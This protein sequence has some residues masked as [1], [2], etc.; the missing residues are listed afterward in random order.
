M[1]VS[2]KFSNP[3]LQSNSTLLNVHARARPV[4]N[5]LT[6]YI[7]WLS[8]INHRPAFLK[9][10]SWGL[11][12]IQENNPTQMGSFH[13]G[14][15]YIR[16]AAPKV[17]VKVMLRQ[18]ISQYVVASSSPWNLWPD[19]IFCLKVAVLSLWSVLSDE[20]SGSVSCQSLSSVFSP[21]S[22]IQYN[23]HCTRTWYLF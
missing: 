12:F 2:F 16:T 5:R 19:I 22:K 13:R 17:K 9:N 23:L 15:R 4:L 6:K 11:D 18:T 3:P 21:L 7:Y 20:R 8:R 1:D 14:N 10:T